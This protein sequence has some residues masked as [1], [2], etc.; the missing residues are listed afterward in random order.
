MSDVGAGI[1][2]RRR[3]WNSLRRRRWDSLRC[4]RHVCRREEVLDFRVELKWPLIS[5]R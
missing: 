1:L 3:L 5:C 4:R 2:L